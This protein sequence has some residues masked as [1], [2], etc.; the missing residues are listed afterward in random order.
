MRPQPV[1]LEIDADLTEKFRDEVGAHVRR[2]IDKYLD[3][4]GLKLI[5]TPIEN[6]MERR[7]VCMKFAIES[8]A[9]ISEAE[10]IVALAR[11]FQ[12]YI[13][14]VGPQLTAEAQE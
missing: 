4:H 10:Q 1:K 7:A 6:A 8:K 2:E 13:E 5:R 11:M 9:W 3:E 14:D 12:E